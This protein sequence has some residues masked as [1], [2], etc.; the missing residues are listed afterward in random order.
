[1]LNIPETR[2]VG[3]YRDILLILTWLLLS[4]LLSVERAPDG[5]GHSCH[6]VRSTA[7]VGLAVVSG[8]ECASVVGEGIHMDPFC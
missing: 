8:E 4:L 6:H 7:E 5:S 2:K 3:L 1:M